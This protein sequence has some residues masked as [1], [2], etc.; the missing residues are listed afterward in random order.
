MPPPFTC[1][2]P[3]RRFPPPPIGFGARPQFPVRSGFPSARRGVAAAAVCVA[4][5][6]STDNVQLGGWCVGL[7]AALT[8]AGT[9]TTTY[10]CPVSVWVVVMSRTTVPFFFSVILPAYMASAGLSGLFQSL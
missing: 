10:I 7:I 6:A 3:H 9:G 8:L 5:A 1:V 2:G 4:G